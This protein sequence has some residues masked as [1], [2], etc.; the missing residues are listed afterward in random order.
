MMNNKDHNNY[1]IKETRNNCPTI[2]SN[3]T[4]LSFISSL[5]ATQTPL[6][7]QSHKSCAVFHDIIMLTAFLFFYATNCYKIKR[8]HFSQGLRFHLIWF[9]K[10]SSLIQLSHIFWLRLAFHQASHYSPLSCNSICRWSA[11]SAVTRYA[12]DQ[13]TQL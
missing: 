4:T 2:S 10:C 7:S 11:H 12:V 13:P 3:L 9:Y 1:K 5:T 6:F 8:H